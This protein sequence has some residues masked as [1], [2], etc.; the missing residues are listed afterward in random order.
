MGLSIAC[1]R[2]HDHKFDPIPTK[3]YYALY[4]V[5][6]SSEEPIELPVIGAGSDPTQTAAYELEKAKRQQAVDDFR[7]ANKAKGGANGDDEKKERDLRKKIAELDSQHAGAPARAM[8][9]NDRKNLHNVK[10]FV[11]GQE[12]N[13]GDEAPRGFLTFLAGKEAKP[14][15][16]GSGR[17]ELARAITAKDNPLTAR[18]MVNRVWA[19]H[20][21]TGLV[22]TPSDFG[23]R[24][25]APLHREL[26][27]WLAARFISDGWSIKKLHRLIMLSSVYRQTSEISADAKR[28]DPDNSMWSRANRLR[29]D[30]ESMRDAL[31]A[32]SG[33]LDQTIGGKA[34]D[35]TKLPFT[36]R[37]TVYGSIDRQNL[38]GVFRSFDFASPDAHTPQRFYTTVPQQ[39][40]FLMNSPFAVEQAKALAKRS[41]SIA[42]PEAR[43][44]ALY[45][46]SLARLPAKDEVKW[47]MDFMRKIDALPVET[48]RAPVWSYGNGRFGI[49]TRTLTLFT[50]LPHF[51]NHVWQG[52]NKL[53]DATL[54]WSLLNADGGHPGGTHEL[55]VVR[56]FTAPTDGV[57]RVSGTLKHP[58]KD[59]D[60]VRGLI[61]ANQ[62]QAL[63]DWVV[64][65]SE[66]STVV[67]RVALKLGQTL[68]FVVDCQANENSDSFSWAP[69]VSLLE[70]GGTWDAH[71]G[72]SGP[73]EKGQQLS[74]WERYAQALLMTNEFVFVD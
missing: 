3:D 16:E 1:A 62:K 33:Q 34:V 42:A 51:T 47:G 20:F 13:Q 39:A 37:R 8:V 36:G 7:A 54:G 64:K 59:G 31:L 6:A 22:R 50:P 73:A 48:E 72:F 2:C 12:S 56:R 57:H 32:V 11:R 58:S 29:L 18:V 69:I 41:E 53:P 21:G 17:A 49:Q 45:R 30:F 4:G 43:I 15:S 68:D 63:G 74:A 70:E 10:V 24:T 25:E 28:L 38:P 9:L 67:E 5:Y 46:F 61:I 35:L 52:G 19:W 26:L 23:L 60:G 14:F 65:T 55:T 66:L 40:L 27:D 71:T 44:Q